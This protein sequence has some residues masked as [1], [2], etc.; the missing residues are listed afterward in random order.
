MDCKLRRLANVGL[1][2]GRRLRGAHQW[3]RLG[4]GLGIARARTK[5]S[6]IPSTTTTQ[7][8]SINMSVYVQS[9]KEL[10]RHLLYKIGGVNGIGF[11]KKMKGIPNAHLS[12]KNNEEV[13]S[14]IYD[15]EVWGGGVG[16]RSGPGS[17]QIATRRLVYLLSDLLNDIKAERVTDIGCGDFGWMKF[18][19][20]DFKYCGVDIVET[21][22]FELNKRYSSATRQFM[23]LDAAKDELPKG[24]TAICREVLFHLS[25]ADAKLVLQNIRRNGYIYLIT[26][27]DG[28]T[29]FNSDVISGDHRPLNLMRPP[30]NFPNPLH[31]IDDDKITS[32]RILACWHIADVINSKSVA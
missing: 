17:D 6:T 28:N 7:K 30:F 5:R 1:E 25:F 18:V 2:P 27:T 4:A 31:T 9:M 11:L 12:G 23:H 20:G 14:S 15:L 32:G 24:D 21:I 26:T 22:V 10:I 3:A 13:F 16:S 19:Q 8:G 29:L